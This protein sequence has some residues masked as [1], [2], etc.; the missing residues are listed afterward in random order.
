MALSRALF[1]DLRGAFRLLED[2]FFTNGHRAL[3][4]SSGPFTNPRFLED[5]ASTPKSSVKEEGNSYYVEAELPGVK[6]QDVKVEFA[7]GGEVLHITGSRGTRAA[8][9]AP[10][11]EIASEGSP[12]SAVNEGNPAVAEANASSVLQTAETTPT[13]IASPW[14]SASNYNTFS[15]TYVSSVPRTLVTIT[16]LML[17]FISLPA[18]PSAR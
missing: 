2:P 14:A 10:T 18:I 11:T 1:N 13:P 12:T 17:T 7:D 8:P 4:P 9:S 15:S 16:A 6:K 5:L 3:Y